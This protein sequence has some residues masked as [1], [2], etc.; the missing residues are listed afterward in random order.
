MYTV[1]SKS[2]L[3]KLLATENITVEH[4]S[5][6]R[7]ASFNIST[8]VLTC[9]IW[10][11]MDGDLYDLLIGHEISH[12]LR[13]PLEGWHDSVTYAGGNKK[14]SAR[15]QKAFKHFLN[16]VED[17]RIEKLVKRQYP[18]LR[19]PM[20]KGYRDLLARDFF[21]LTAVQDLNELYLIDK[22]NLSAKVGVLLNVTFTKEEQPFYDEMQNLETFDDVLILARKL[23]AYSKEEQ[24]KNAEEEKKEEENQ[25]AEQQGD[26]EDSGSEK[27]DESEEG[28]DSGVTETDEGEESDEESEGEESPESGEESE[29][30]GGEDYDSEGESEGDSGDEDHSEDQDS[31]LG[32][33]GQPGAEEYQ[34]NQEEYD[35]NF[36]P[37]ARTDE[38][39]RH[40]ELSLVD[41]GNIRSVYIEIPTPNLMDVVTPVAIVNKGLNDYYCG[42][43]EREVANQLLAEF[44]AKNEDYVSLLAKEF[45]MKKAARSFNQSRRAET[46]DIN[47]SKL[48]SY[49]TEDNIFKKLM[50]V[51]KGKSHG[52]VLLQDRSSSMT[53]HIESATE[54]ILIKAMFCRKVNIPFVAYTFSDNSGKVAQHDFG[55]RANY[56]RPF[57]RNHNE[58]L[59][60]N[61]EFREILNSK[62]QGAEFNNSMANQLLLSRELGRRSYRYKSTTLKYPR[63]PDF[64][65]PA[66]EDMGSTPLNE[67]III[68]RDVVKKFKRTHLLDIVN[69][70]IVHDGDSDRNFV[71]HGGKVPYDYDKRFGS[72]VPEEH[73]FDPSYDRVTVRDKKENVDFVCPQNNRGLQT[74]LLSWFQATSGCGIFG[75]YITGKSDDV[76]DALQKM[77]V[78]KLGIALG[79]AEKY[80]KNYT[81]RALLLAQ[82]QLRMSEEKFIESYSTGYTR[83][84]FIPGSDD[85]A[86]DNGEMEN[87]SPTGKWTANRLLAAFKKVSKKRV[88]SRVLVSRFIDLIAKH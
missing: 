26:E 53:H 20:F 52:V 80:S 49:R 23:Y 86:A 81:D 11:N 5:K 55:V 51:N 10:K 14:A 7:T 15:E 54:Q 61:I 24:Q 87:A 9:P 88:V 6:A 71:F 39:F 82:L 40:R 4:Q 3:A 13:T 74:A 17:A 85:L 33:E 1:Q 50:I 72:S 65:Y 36:V 19:N 21:G 77:Y 67:A 84:F 25:Q 58:F 22:L 66:H 75:F 37:K 30:S 47:I 63:T 76:K 29:E 28:S 38:A 59:T 41:T 34:D 2:L 69:A 57:S 18:G 46:G 68:L 16:V 79:P 62:M 43:P 73:R 70:I 27:S 60:T 12:A 45:E 48:A 32:S 35:E 31:D 8:R 83:F 42:R 44:K 78:N 64:G 56:L